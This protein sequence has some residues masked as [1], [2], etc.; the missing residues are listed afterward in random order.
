M[1][2]ILALNPGGIGDQI[3]FF[4]TLQGLRE[5]FPQD[6]IE[7]LVE[8]RS[9]VA[10]RVCPWV[11]ETL[12][13]DFKADL[14]LADWINLIGTIRDR[15]Y[16]AALSVGS[17]SGVSILLWITGIRERIGY[18]AGPSSKLLTRP[19]TLNRDQYAAHM[20]YD[21]L[22]GFNIERPFT[23]PRIVIPAEDEQ[24]ALQLLQQQGLTDKKP[25]LLHPGASKLSASKGIQKLYPVRLWVEAVQSLARRDIPLMVVQGPE[26][27]ELVNA[28]SAS[29]G[30]QI[31]AVAPP[32]IG[33]LAALIHHSRLL[34]CVDSAPMH[35]GVATQ[36]PLV[37]LFGPTSPAKLLPE[38]P[39]F[40]AVVSPDNTSVERIP[41]QKVVQAV[42]AQLAR[43]QVPLS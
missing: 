22:Q 14:S 27:E 41:V 19:V 21:L 13:F 33:K 2:R 42:K 12:P 4:P 23:V 26:D 10:Y 3:L 35:L 9:R 39:Q 30:G 18:A 34:L 1:R 40:T 6:R 38:A 8:P 36:T 28:L 31:Q 15:S 43:S 16:S 5:S 37:A 17:S 25:L 20:Y 32:D 7:V 24:W 29:L 11:N